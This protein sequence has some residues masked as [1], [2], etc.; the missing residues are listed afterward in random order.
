MEASGSRSAARPVEGLGT[1]MTRPAIVR[2]KPRRREEGFALVVDPVEQR[3]VHTAL[4]MYRLA[5]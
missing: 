2:E 4:S 1:P 5:S 3:L